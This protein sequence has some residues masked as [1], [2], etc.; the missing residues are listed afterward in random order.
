MTV[1]NSREKTLIKIK[2]CLGDILTFNIQRIDKELVE[3]YRSLHFRNMY[4]LNDIL[5]VYM[6]YSIL[7]FN[8]RLHPVSKFTL[9]QCF[10]NL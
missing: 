8:Q 2:H 7:Q 3:M 4:S 5:V 1:K 9:L 10:C 6:P